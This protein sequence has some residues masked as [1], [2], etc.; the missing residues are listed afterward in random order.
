M[1]PI[2][3]LFEHIQANEQLYHAL[4][5]GRG[6]ELFIEKGQEYW[7]R[8]IA[9]DLQAR[10]PDGQQPLVPVPVIAHFV[11]GTLVTMLSWWL[12]NKM[13]YSPEQMDEMI[14][15]LVMPGVRNCVP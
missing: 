12:E 5:N 13:P 11:A 2:R 10:L 1:L 7:S 15:K 6:L 14:E 8:K 9:A 3:E 4:V